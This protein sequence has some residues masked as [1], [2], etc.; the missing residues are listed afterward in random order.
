MGNKIKIA[1]AGAGIVIT[2][3]FCY[4]FLLGTDRETAL[5]PQ[6][7]PVSADASPA[8]A[9][10]DG[11]NIASPAPSPAGPPGNTPEMNQMTIKDKIVKELQKNYGGTISKIS[12]QAS[13]YGVRNYILS[14]FPDDGGKTFSEIIKRAF[15]DFAD[16]IM[17]TLN[18]LD[19]YNQWLADNEAILAM[20]SESEKTAALWEKREALF[21]DAAKEIWSGEL[22]A[23]D[24]RKKTMQ[25]TMAVLQESRDTTIE[26]KLDM[27]NAALHETYDNSP[28]EFILEYKD[29]SA[30]VFFSLDSVQDELKKLPPDQRQFEMNKI[31]R[32]MGFTQEDIEKMEEYDAVREKRWE[33]G[34]QYM[35]ERDAVAAESQGPEQEEKLKA[36]RE[37]YFQDE[38]QT[39]ELEEKD[40]FFRFKRERVY[41]RN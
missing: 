7:V 5:A 36:I 18:K 25:D 2:M 23:T 27:F 40:D 13:L 41:G 4:L 8:S 15:P 39:I 3:I 14:M 20:M 24:A 22:L 16:A 1:A 37:K 17:A 29:M 35:A 28:E 9:P 6:H 21:G 11:K 32:E 31:R 12:T 30:K 34:L 38:A 10:A 26:E 19:T 33:V